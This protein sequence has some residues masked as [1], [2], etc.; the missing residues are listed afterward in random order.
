MPKYFNLTHNNGPIFLPTAN[1]KNSTV[2]ARLTEDPYVNGYINGKELLADTPCIINSAF[3]KGNIVL[4]TF[5]PQFR[6]QS[7]ATFK[8]LFNLLYEY[9]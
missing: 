4:Y 3:G 8:L 5:N 7:D 1:S 9:E 2:V 6:N